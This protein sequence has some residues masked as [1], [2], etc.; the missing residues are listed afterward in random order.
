MLAALGGAGKW[1]LNTATAVG[2]TL[3]AGY[4]KEKLGIP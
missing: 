4:L 2:A 1:V 3:V